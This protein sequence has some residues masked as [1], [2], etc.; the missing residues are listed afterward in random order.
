MVSL[1]EGEVSLN[2]IVYKSPVH[3]SQ[4]SSKKGR[5]KR[6]E[7]VRFLVN[8]NKLFVSQHLKVKKK[9]Q[10]Q[11]NVIPPRINHLRF[12]QNISPHQ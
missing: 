3:S 12:S 2:P 11:V 4:L 8:L 10:S 9:P 6:I 5:I 1:G 7:T